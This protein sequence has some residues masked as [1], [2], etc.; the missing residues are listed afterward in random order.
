MQWLDDFVRESRLK[1]DDRVK[2]ALWCRGVSDEQIESFQIGY[3][4]GSIPPCEAPSKFLDWSKN[5]S[6]LAD[7]FVFPLTNSLG[8]VQGVQFRS[9]DRELKTFSDFFLSRAEPTFLGLGQASL[10]TWES[11]KVILVEGT[12]DLFPVQRV[13]SNSISTLTAKVDD[14]LARWLSR[15]VEEVILFYDN[16]KAG[17]DASLD[18]QKKHSGD[19]KITQI[20]FPRGVLLPTGKEAKDPSD[21]WEAWGEDRFHD[22]LV[23][24]V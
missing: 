1:L 11:S 4:D 20:V 8:E 3:I 16:D 14:T 5:G 13:F 2:E 23:S 22:F 12:F 10:P 6:R 17:R 7:S 15:V 24:Q 9:V 21:L 19:L 18:Y